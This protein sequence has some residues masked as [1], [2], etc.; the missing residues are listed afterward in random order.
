M[1]MAKG[2]K[3]LDPKQAKHLA[4]TLRLLM[5]AKHPD[6]SDT[7]VARTIGVPQSQLSSALRGENR[8]SGVQ[9]LIR[10]REHFRVSIDDLL[11]LS[12]L[13]SKPLPR[14]EM[15]AVVREVLVTIERAKATL[16]APTPEP[17]Q[18]PTA[19]KKKPD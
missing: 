8:S 10:I 19:V 4:K 18:L 14:E 13:P 5:K 6:L 15:E 17:L 1:W 11:G 3:G 12:L 2:T 9:G 16:P 7:E